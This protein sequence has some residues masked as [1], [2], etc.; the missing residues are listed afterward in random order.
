LTACYLRAREAAML[1]PPS[2]RAWLSDVLIALLIDLMSGH[3]RPFLGVIT[4]R[5]CRD[6]R[7]RCAAARQPV[8]VL[9]PDLSTCT[10]VDR[11]WSGGSL[12][13]DQLIRDWHAPGFGACSF[14]VHSHTREDR[15]PNQLGPLA[16]RGLWDIMHAK[17]PA[18][19]PRPLSDSVQFTVAALSPRRAARSILV[20]ISV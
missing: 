8:A 16:M 4:L 20:F 6:P 17:Q 1:P 18:N 3:A 19:G 11:P 2:S 10:Y 9:V 7:L 15:P 12:A 13:E 5:A 14:T